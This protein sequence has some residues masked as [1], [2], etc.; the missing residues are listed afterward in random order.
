MRVSVEVDIIAPKEKVWDAIT[1]IGN[2]T[3]MISGIVALEILHQPTDGLI[4]LKWTETRKMFGKEASE[5]MWITD[6]E[7]LAYYSTRAESHGAVYI[8]KLSIVEA[9]DATRLTLSFSTASDSMVAKFLASVMGVVMKRSMR[10]ML[11]NDVNDI[12]EFIESH[13]S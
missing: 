11:L 12:K 1:N 7:D 5:I 6:C 10:K 3:E 8:S 13:D 2:S 4:G 9:G